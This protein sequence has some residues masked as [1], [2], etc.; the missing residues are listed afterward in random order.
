MKPVRSMD[1]IDKIN[2]PSHL[3]RAILF[4]L[5]TS[6]TSRAS[7]NDSGI[8]IIIIIV[9]IGKLDAG[10]HRGG[11][12]AQTYRSSANLATLRVENAFYGWAD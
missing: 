3:R 9:A 12:I 5:F 2:R 10:V 4:D 7:P 8:V 11:I 6:S 1:V